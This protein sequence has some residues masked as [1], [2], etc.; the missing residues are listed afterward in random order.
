MAACLILVLVAFLLAGGNVRAEDPD[1]SNDIA[2]AQDL[3]VGTAIAGNINPGTDVDYFKIDLSTRSGDVDLWVYA[4]SNFD[5][6]GTLWDSNASEI[7]FSNDNPFTT[8]GVDFL[9]AES[10]APGIYYVSIGSVGDSMTGEYT[11]H[12]AIP[13]TVSMDTNAS[14]TISQTG[15]L[16]VYKFD[17]SANAD[18]T[19]V[20]I[21][22]TGGTD[23]YGRLLDVDGNEITYNDDS[24]FSTVP[25]DFTIAQTLSPATYYILVGNSAGATGSYTLNMDART[26]V[27]GKIRDVK[28]AA[29]LI[30]DTPIDGIIG[31]GDQDAYRL[32]L[33]S[34]TD[35][36]LY[37]STDADPIV[38]DTLG[39]LFDEVGGSIEQ[40]DDSEFIDT[41]FDFFMAQT[42]D[43]GTYYIAVVAARG[44]G[45]YRLHVNELPDVTT[46]FLTLNPDGTAATVSILGTDDDTDS[47]TFTPTGTKDVF[48]YTFGPTDTQGSMG[49]VENDDGGLSYGHRNFFVADNVSGN[50]TVTVNGF[51]GDTGVYRMVVETA[52]DHGATTATAQELTNSPVF[53]VIHS[54]TDTDLFKLDLTSETESKYLLLYTTGNTD[55]VGTLLTHDG[56]DFLTVTTDDDSGVG[57]NFLIGRELVP[58]EYYLRVESFSSPGGTARTGPYALF[59]ETAF[60]LE[61]DG[62]D[63]AEGGI[64]HHHDQDWFRIDLSGKTE[65]TDVWI[66]SLGGVD[67]F[68]R[69]YDSD[70]NE[71]ATNDDSDLF[72][73]SSSFNIREY[74][75]PGIYYVNVSSFDTDTG[76]YN[77]SAETAFD[78]GTLELGETRPGTIGSAEERDHILLDLGGKSNVILFVKGITA[79]GPKLTVSGQSDLNEYTYPGNE[80]VVRDNFSGSPTITVT[81]DEPGTYTIQALD[82]GSYT[83]FVANCLA[84]ANALDP[85]VGD[86]LYACQWHLENRREDAEEED[87]DVEAVWED[88]T[89]ADGS[90][91]RDGIR[92]QGI[93]VA[94]VDDG[95]DI[96][97]PDLSPNVNRRLN[98]DYGTDGVNQASEHHGTAVAGVIAARDNSFGVRGVAPRATI[99]SYNFLTSP[100]DL[101]AYDSMTR[102]INVTAVSNNSWGP[103]DGPGPGFAPIGWEKAVEKGVSEGY[104]GRGVFYAFAAGNGAL[105]GDDANLDEYANFYAVTGVCAVNDAGRRSDFSEAG[106]SLWVC[107]PSSNLRRGHRGIAT[108]E[109]SNRY[110]YT[111]GGTSSAA[112]MVAGVAALVRQANPGLTWRD[113]KLILAATARKN[114]DT[115]DDWESGA[116]K[117]GESTGTYNWNREYGFGVVNAKAAVDAAKTWTRLPSLENLGQAASKTLNLTIPDGSA[118]GVT[119]SLSIVSDI[120]FIEFVEV[121]AKFSHPSFRDLEI[122]LRS[123]ASG[124]SVK[125]LSH[126]A[127]DEPI[128]L[129][130]IIRFGASRFLGE[131]PDGTWTLT[132]RDKLGNRL[133]GSLDSWTIKTYGHKP[134]PPAPIIDIVPEEEAGPVETYDRDNDGVISRAEVIEAVED[135]FDGEISRAELLEVIAAYLG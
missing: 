96:N 130:G 21:Y 68:G 66:S 19:D 127:S 58:G 85:T 39:A 61:L 27:G 62:T 47:Y 53:G 46:Q 92:G 107:G 7:A 119:S 79:A 95:M 103:A 35:V 78:P 50:Q 112:P 4:F 67:S 29:A 87:I 100:S 117:Y 49:N 131:H 1:F 76:P 98:H 56:A 17:L 52:D 102:N 88:T 34:T 106:A 122:E 60:S 64:S 89:L 72:G 45:P 82:D 108:T 81:A 69:L 93:K 33:F 43:P 109:N 116:V 90:T 10:L 44:A 97:H 118:T 3:T 113:V 32:D 15:E 54:A 38:V 84:E 135:Y 123:P 99:F 5:S 25:L 111:F 20:W 133:S 51:E 6:M 31:P 94:V 13:G 55:T 120:E 11:L 129:N 110:R 16:D 63:P 24:I 71:I 91:V 101:S 83:D 73:R 80:F 14:G 22:T 28:D 48:V 59:S 2:N 65:N 12:V 75:D 41:P 9:I 70:L 8:S 104:S 114:H 86:D 128:P 125:L 26:D 74:L 37:T 121:R 124:T 36:V 42:L 132:L 105:R 40:V 134:G 23:T 126:Y 18:P 57:L 30:L 77:L 115:S